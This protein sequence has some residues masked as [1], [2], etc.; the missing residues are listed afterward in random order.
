MSSSL[1]ENQQEDGENGME[2]YL[3]LSVIDLRRTSGDNLDRMNLGLDTS[4]GNDRHPT[5]SKP[6]GFRNTTES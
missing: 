2:V 4:E 3:L 5:L 6:F 1:E